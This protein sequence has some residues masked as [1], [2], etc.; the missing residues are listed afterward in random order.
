MLSKSSFEFIE[1]ECKYHLQP[2]T[3]EQ[4]AK[5]FFHL[6]RPHLERFNTMRFH[7][8]DLASTSQIVQYVDFELE[9]KIEL[10]LSNHELFTRIMPGS[11][12]EIK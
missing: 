6:M 11:A 4:K 9:G 1:D 3:S 10:H 2:L 5:F 12:R 8:K 7:Y